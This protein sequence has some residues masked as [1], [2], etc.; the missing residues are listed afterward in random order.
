MPDWVPNIPLALLRVF[1]TL[2]FLCGPLL[3]ELGWRTVRLPLGQSGWMSNRSWW[4]LRC[5]SVCSGSAALTPTGSGTDADVNKLI[6]E[7]EK[8]LAIR[9]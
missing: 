3:I 2:F 1:G 4:E 9:L 7:G 6:A 8:L 5:W